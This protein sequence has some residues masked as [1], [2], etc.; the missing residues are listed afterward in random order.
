MSHVG[1][2]TGGSTPERGVALSGAGQVVKALRSAGHVVTVADT[3]GGVLDTAQEGSRLG[4]VEL[5]TLDSRAAAVWQF[6]ARFEQEQAVFR[7]SG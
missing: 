3:C 7:R 2:L 5:L 6:A 1:L 4:W